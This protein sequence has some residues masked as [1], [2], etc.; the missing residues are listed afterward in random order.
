MLKIIPVISLIALASCQNSDGTYGQ[1]GSVAW[2]ESASQS[3]RMNHF[4][5]LCIGY[6]FKEGTADMARCIQEEAGRARVSI[7]DYY[8]SVAP[9]Q[10]T[11]TT[12]GNVTNCSSY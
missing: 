6:G 12:M 2:L 5:G 7:A 3:Q 8:Q 9:Q 4:T 10:T 11:C 1:V